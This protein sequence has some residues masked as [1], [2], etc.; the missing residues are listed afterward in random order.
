[1]TN[2]KALTYRQLLDEMVAI[3]RTCVRADRVKK[4]GHPVRTNE[5]TLPLDAE[6]AAQKALFLS[7]SP[8]DRE[9]LSRLIASEREAAVHDVLAYLEWATTTEAL[10]IG[11]T[12]QPFAGK[13]DETMRGDFVA[14]LAGWAWRK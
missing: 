10:E 5:T 14:R 7:L 8:R 1:M 2:A 13:A 3:A 4:H 6:E 9:L 11:S 12:A